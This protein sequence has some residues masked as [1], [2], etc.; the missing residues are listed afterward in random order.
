[1]IIHIVKDNQNLKTISNNYNVSKNDIISNNKHI[2]DW[3]NLKL[4]MK[5]KIP[6]LNE[7]VNNELEESEPF[8]E[9]YYLK[10]EDVI[11]EEIYEDSIE[12]LKE[13]SIID[14]LDEFIE[15][16]KEDES[17]NTNI[18]NKDLT[19]KNKGEKIEIKEEEK[20]DKKISEQS[21]NDLEKE[22]IKIN[23]NNSSKENN[24]NYERN[25]SN[26]IL[27][28]QYND[29]YFKMLEQ[30][31]NYIKEY[32]NYYQHYYEYYRKLYGKRK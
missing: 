11:N 23:D 18:E 22:Q 14:N 25:L 27:E 9:D 29:Y 1:M 16:R 7:E 28:N 19:S 2:S 13:D 5:I 4:G 20:D 6:L 8:I 12:D 10:K 32:Q 15:E 3:Q 30:Y 31:Q 26:D 17:L 24:I 21:I